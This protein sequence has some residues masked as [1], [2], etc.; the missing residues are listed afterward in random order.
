MNQGIWVGSNTIWLASG[1]GNSSSTSSTGI[2]QRYDISNPKNPLRHAYK[3]G[4]RQI[5]ILP[6]GSSLDQHGHDVQG[7]LNVGLIKDVAEYGKYITT[8]HTRATGIGADTHDLFIHETDSLINDI[9]EVGSLS[10]SRIKDAYRVQVHGKYAWV[11]TNRTYSPI[12]SALGPQTQGGSLVKA[13]LTAVDISNPS[14]P[15]VADSFEEY[16]AGASLG[17]GGS[18]PGSVG[19]GTKYLDFDI[20]DGK[21]FVLRYTNYVATSTPPNSTHR[22]DLLV[23]DA[24]DPSNFSSLTTYV[25]NG[26]STPTTYPYSPQD[27]VNLETLDVNTTR[28]EFGGLDTQNQLTYVVWEDSLYI[29]ELTNNDLILRSTTSLSIESMNACD[30][31]VRGKYAYILV[32][33]S[34]STGSVQV[35]D[36]SNKNSPFIVSEI[37]NTNLATSSRL[38]ISGKY[39]YVVSNSG[40]TV[41]LITLDITGIDSP[42]AQIGAIKTNDL[43]V[44]GNAH[45]RNNLQVKNSLNVGPGGIYIDQGQG[46]SSDGPISINSILHLSPLDSAPDAAQNGDIYYDKHTNKLRVYAAGSWV[47]LN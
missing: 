6:S 27:L 41:E 45:I 19:E 32:N 30:I 37:R 28:T 26:I 31:V 34:N 39:I 21:A 2:I 47:N 1:A 13:K 43:Q 4:A 10:D 23:F 3:I 14:L 29:S 35:W 36:I 42:A 16:Y 17:S 20:K 11:I 25:D 40:T 24:Q 33:Y 38:N 5:S 18:L 46:L 12:A 22:L 8:I 44:A 15:V 9:W 7:T